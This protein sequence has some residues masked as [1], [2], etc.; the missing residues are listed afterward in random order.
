MSPL[1]L[2]FVGNFD[3][4]R[5]S[6]AFITHKWD[7]VKSGMDLLTSYDTIAMSS[8]D[9]PSTHTLS[10]C[11]SLVD[12]AISHLDLCTV[13]AFPYLFRC[14]LAAFRRLLPNAT[15]SNNT[16]TMTGRSGEL[17]F[18]QFNQLLDIGW[19]T[20]V[21]G[22]PWLD[23]HTVTAFIELAFDASVLRYVD[24]DI[25]K[26]YFDK[27]F[28]LSASRP[29]VMQIMVSHLCAVWTA[30]PETSIQFFPD[31]LTLLL[32][33]EPPQD[34]HSTTDPFGEVGLSK[35]Q[36]ETL[37]NEDV[38]TQ[39]N[40]CRILILS[41][42]ENLMTRLYSSTPTD[43]GDMQGGGNGMIIQLKDCLENLVKQLVRLNLTSEFVTS[44]MIGTDFFG[45][46]LRSW[47]ALCV[48]THCVSETLLIDI[49]DDYF[50]TLCCNCAHGIRVH[51]EIF[52]AAMIL[53]HRGILLPRLL[54]E[55]TCFNFA[56]QHLSS[57]F[58]IL[59]F[60]VEAHCEKSTP[61]LD[62]STIFQLISHLM[63]WMACA[64]G[65]PRSIAQ[66]SLHTLIPLLK[67]EEEEGQEE[68]QGE[69]QDESSSNNDTSMN[70]NNTNNNK[71]SH[72]YAY[73]SLNALRDIFKFLDTH[74]DSAKLIPRQRAFFKEYSLSRRCTVEG[75][76]S[77]KADNVGEIVPPHLLEIIV[78]VISE[79]AEAQALEAATTTT[80][81]ITSSS[82]SSSMTT[83]TTSV[84]SKESCD[85]GVI[86]GES[87]DMLDR[88]GDSK[89]NAFP[90]MNYS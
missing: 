51:M 21:Q 82:S 78:D 13:T 73:I 69:E 72:S 37:I 2:D 17:I 7:A 19:R 42:L 9:S 14:C 36:P 39:Q 67:E 15:N 18:S 88:G 24:F 47:Q 3:F 55:L 50:Q 64:P 49:L 46:K 79:N 45:R 8:S 33:K 4:S 34:D 44:A 48:L 12:T 81:T 60:L 71:T 23:I 11:Q 68:G 90:L 1:L 28:K 32:Y 40:M 35:L 26:I 43:F 22:T 41:Y 66:M 62:N 87:G 83:S 58:I 56:Q 57:F 27:L 20:G 75:L 54:K 16:N 89:P 61:P 59:G 86:E 65:L 52:G 85:N 76:V 38:G 77:F 74:K 5:A 10:R 29:H 31:I 84:T 30:F 70:L 63:P 25:T 53:K 6:S 80:T